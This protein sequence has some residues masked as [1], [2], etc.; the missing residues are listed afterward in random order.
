MCAASPKLGVGHDLG[1]RRAVGKYLPHAGDDDVAEEQH[2]ARD[3]QAL[4]GEIGH[5]VSRL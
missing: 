3:M 4:E 1:L 5:E 2:H